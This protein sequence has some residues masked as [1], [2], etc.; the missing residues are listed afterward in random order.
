MNNKKLISWVA[1]I[2][3]L[4]VFSGC[5]GQPGPKFNLRYTSPMPGAVSKGSVA[6]QIVDQRPSDKGGVKKNLIGQET[7]LMGRP[8]SNIY[9]NQGEEPTTILKKLVSES[10][11]SAGYQPVGPMVGVPTLTVALTSFWLTGLKTYTMTLNAN[12]SLSGGSGGTWSEVLAAVGNST[13]MG[14]NFR[15]SIEAGYQTMLNTAVTQLVQK[16]NGPAFQAA[17]GTPGAPPPT[18]PAVAPAT[19]PAA[20]AT[21][22]AA[23]AA[24]ECKLNSD[25][26]I[27][28]HCSANTCIYECREDRDCSD[29]QVCDTQNGTCKKAKKKKSK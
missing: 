16:F 29:N 13:T 6:V 18:A 17:V 14:L 7:N 28:Q 24:V 9:S 19:A 20:P 22:P 2:A 25:C 5:F 23:P 21:A 8:I 27:G 11:A 15:A 3:G 26:P 4:A 12:L 10:L 1:L